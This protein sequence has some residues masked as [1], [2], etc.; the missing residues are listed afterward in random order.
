MCAHMHDVSVHIKIIVYE[1]TP[2]L[3]ELDVLKST[4]VL[5][6]TYPQNWTYPSSW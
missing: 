6:D 1:S 5:I 2:T 3:R 4:F